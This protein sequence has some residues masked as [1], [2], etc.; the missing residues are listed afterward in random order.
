MNIQQAVW[1]FIKKYYINSIVYKTGYNVVNTLTWAALLIVAVVLLYKFLVK[2][3]KIDEKFIYATIPYIVFG[4]AT[5]I[6]EDANF[7][8]PPI[9]YAFMSPFIYIIVFAL[10]FPALLISLKLFGSER[11]Y[12]PYAAFG[13]ILAVS[14][15][16]FLFMNLRVVNYWVIPAGLG[17]AVIMTAIFYVIMPPC[18]NRL[19]ILVFFVH[20]LDGFET[21]LG[22]SFLNYWELHVLPRFL[23]YHFGPISLP[24]AKFV[25]FALILYLLDTSGEEENL[26]NFIKFA[27]IVLGLGPGLRDG[28]RM[29]FSV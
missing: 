19:S 7:L 11:Y 15:L 8:K 1:D 20:M 27:L 9:A 28:L 5:R 18:R 21:F 24:I 16:T 23:I 4:S 22:I 14:M 25:V 13:I 29:T 17:L 3:I 6:V 12:K 2:R 26:K 10:T